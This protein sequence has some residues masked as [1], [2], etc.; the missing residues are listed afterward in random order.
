MISSSNFATRHADVQL[1]FVALFSNNGW[2][3]VARTV[4]NEMHSYENKKPD[5]AVLRLNL[6]SSTLSLIP[7][8]YLCGAGKCAEHA[9]VYK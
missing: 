3:K 8:D 7:T 5:A 2:I 9:S 6:P 4:P 1:M